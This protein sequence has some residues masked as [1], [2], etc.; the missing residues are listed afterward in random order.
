MLASPTRDAH[1][2]TSD[3]A[4]VATLI[5]AEYIEMPCLSV[6]LA[7]AARLWN[8]DRHECLEILESLMKEGFLHRSRDS[9]RRAG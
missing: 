6:T 2:S 7:Q 4:Y 1:R 8:I 3:P 5:R 9:Y